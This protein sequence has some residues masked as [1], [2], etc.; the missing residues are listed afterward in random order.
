MPPTSGHPKPRL[1]MFFEAQ[2]RCS[3]WD[4]T[5][6]QGYKGMAARGGH[7]WRGHCL[8]AEEDLVGKDGTPGAGGRVTAHSDTKMLFAAT[9]PAGVVSPSGL[10]RDMG[11]CPCG[12]CQASHGAQVSLQ[13]PKQCP[14]CRAPQMALEAL[15]ADL[16][17]AGAR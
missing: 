9:A 12:K 17:A 14:A 5:V 16:H 8:L 10:K 6:L 7:S 13:P 3:G 2:Q 11:T 1:G 15:N 4:L